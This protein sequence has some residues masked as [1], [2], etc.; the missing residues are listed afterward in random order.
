MPYYYASADSTPLFVMAMKDYVNSS[1]DV[2]F[3][4]SHWNNVKQA[5]A[6]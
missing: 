1:G 2:A 3:L 6:Y 4:R 5:Y